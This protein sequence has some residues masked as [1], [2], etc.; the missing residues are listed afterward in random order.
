ML[1]VQKIWASTKKNCR[2][3]MEQENVVEEVEETLF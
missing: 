1:Q 3:K 2:T